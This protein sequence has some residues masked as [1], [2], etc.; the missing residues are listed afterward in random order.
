MPPPP[1]DAISVCLP[2]GHY[3]ISALNNTTY[4][5]R[6]GAGFPRI[7]AAALGSFVGLPVSGVPYAD[8]RGSSPTETKKRAS[9]STVFSIYT[10]MLYLTATDHLHWALP[11][12]Q[13]IAFELQR[14]PWKGRLLPSFAA[15]C[16][17]PPLCASLGPLDAKS[18]SKKCFLCRIRGVTYISLTCPMLL[19]VHPRFVVCGV[20]YCCCCVSKTYDAFK[21][22]NCFHNESKMNNS[23]HT[24]CNPGTLGGESARVREGR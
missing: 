21:R 3:S 17:L 10:N 18:K 16:N 22:V 2:A 7:P 20:W 24:T 4:V 13:Y 9:R 23:P 8:S 11:D 19:S 12:L 5:S 6:R 1:P 14:Q 15:P